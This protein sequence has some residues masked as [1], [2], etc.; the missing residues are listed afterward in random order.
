MALQYIGRLAHDP[1]T[2]TLITKNLYASRCWIKRSLSCGVVLTI[3]GIAGTT[4]AADELGDALLSGTF[5]LD[6]RARH[7]MADQDGLSRRA[8]AN[9]VRTRISYEVGKW[10]GF[11]ALVEAE[12]IFVP[13]DDR[14]N[15]TIN[16][17]SDFP[18]VRD[19]PTTELNQYWLGYAI[20]GGGVV[21]L[22]RQSIDLGARTFVT[23]ARFRQN[24]QTYDAATIIARPLPDLTLLFGYTWTIDRT[25]GEDAVDGDWNTATHMAHVAYDGLPPVEIAG[26]AL[27]MDLD[28][29]PALSALTLGARFDG[30]FPHTDSTSLITRGELA[31]QTDYADNPTDFSEVLILAEAGAGIAGLEGVL[32]YRRQSGNGRAALQ[33]TIGMKHSNR[34]W[35][36]KFSTTPPHGLV[37][38]YVALT[39]EP[40]FLAILDLGP[41]TRQWLDRTQ[42]RA[43][44]N[45]FSSDGGG[46]RYGTEFDIGFRQRL[47]DRLE[48]LLEYADY[49][50]KSYATDTR[51]MWVTLQFKL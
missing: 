3:C 29:R 36:D 32:G 40:G 9:T 22:G 30:T 19:A 35:A 21:K 27:A 41:Q 2:N 10:R 37:N 23:S 49:R 48:F 17:R 50:A 24:Q 51:K 31:W 12:N 28:E 42:I 38:T 26:Y 43:G 6:V 34:G 5:K 33:T 14:F 20:P 7:E 25:V 45:R 44:Y 46:T 47:Y 1:W 18:V 39:I 13:G 4:E 11:S 8:S 15:D 16:G